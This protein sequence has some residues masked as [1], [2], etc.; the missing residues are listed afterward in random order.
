M[1][2]RNIFDMMDERHDFAQEINRL[3]TLLL[4][5]EGV[6]VYPREID[7]ELYSP[8]HYSVEE[9]VDKFL[10][11]KWKGRGNCIDLHDMEEVLDL[12]RVFC[13]DRP[14]KEL[15]VMFLE[16]A[17]NILYVVENVTDDINYRRKMTNVVS[18]AKKNLMSVLDWMNYET[19]AF[20]DM[21]RVLVVAKNAAATAVAE[22]VNVDL[23]HL[24]IEY[25]HHSLAGN[26]EKKK[27]ILLA[28]GTELEPKRSELKKIN[29]QFDD[30]YFMLN[31]LNI[32]H[33]NKSKS[34]G[35]YVEYVAKMKKDKLE[36]WYD[37]LYQ[38]MLLAYLELDQQ[39]RAVRVN[40]LKEKIANHY[41]D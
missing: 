1:E 30:I 8:K 5:G 4:N 39:D 13:I 18:A 25:N 26:V 36:E 40:E 34:N 37:E 20:K 41:N 9:Y 28:M 31:N 17:A 7:L 14:S 29:K 23:A 22:I 24:V 32:R 19:K 27:A 16:Y 38:M 15:V 33:N 35:K 12:D 10:F 3:N 2:R 21:E 11:K 6:V